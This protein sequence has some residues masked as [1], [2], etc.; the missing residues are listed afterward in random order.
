MQLTIAKKINLSLVVI[1]LLI[2]TITSWI[3][4]EDEKQLAESLV[5]QNIQGLA[6]NYFDSVNTMMLTG[7]IANRH[8]I[9]EKIQ[10]QK[11]VLEAR[12]LRSEQLNQMFGQGQ[13]DQKARSDF[14]KQGLA[15]VQA[16]AISE[17]GKDRVMEFVMPIKASKDFRGTNCLAC[18]QAKEGDILGAVKIAYN[19]SALDNE[20]KESITHA[21]IWQLFITLVCFGLLSWTLYKLVLLR[22]KK[23]NR[24]IS[25]T[26]KN[27]DLSNELEVKY[28]DEIGEVSISFN[29]MMASFKGILSAVSGANERLLSSAQHVDEIAELTKKGLLEQKAGTDSV[30]AAINQLDASAGDVRRNTQEAAEKSLQTYD[31]ANQS[32]TIAEKTTQDINDLKDKVI[33]NAQ[34]IAELEK[35]S[36]DVGGVLEVI[37]GI[38]EQTNLLALNAAIEAARAGEQGRGF[39]V[40]A[41]EVRSLANRT[42]E[43]IKQ[44]QATIQG[45][46]DGANMAVISMQQ[47]SEQ[48]NEKAQ[49][50]VELSALLINITEQVKSLEQLNGEI[51]HAA[52]QQNLAADEINQNVV[53]ISNVAEQSS[54][55]AVRSKEVSEQLLM[56]S[57]E[58]NAQIIK[59]KL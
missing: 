38:A 50:V 22:L 30:A 25:A 49:E 20:I 55:E 47:V 46:Q 27:L 13:A 21:L 8:L 29:K 44:I 45:L 58:L 33:D 59:F 4:Y 36:E 57:E 10:S 39:A 51:A 26:E 11:N 18:H 2:M 16:F 43:S 17:L 40:V 41:D 12:I 56:L 1:S 23:L 5:E 53:N 42:R 28:Q 48:A 34:H 37:T 6:V 14:E 24:C 35:Q 54:A 32:L 15:G 52:E 3:F 19:L 9:Q 7:T 31:S